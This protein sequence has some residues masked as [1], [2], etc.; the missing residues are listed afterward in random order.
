MIDILAKHDIYLENYSKI[1][2][3]RKLEL[4]K[5][6]VIALVL[7]IFLCIFI[8]VIGKEIGELY[9]ISDDKMYESLAK[10]Y[11]ITSNSIFD[12]EALKQIG[13]TQ[14]LQ[15]FWPYVVCVFAYLFRS[16][17]AARFL[18]VVLSIIAVKLIYDLVLNISENH[19]TAMRAAKLY[20][21]LPYPLL[22]CCFPI[23]DIYL[24]VAVLYT[25]ILFVKFQNRKTI[26]LKNYF[27]CILL[28]IGVYFTRGAVVEIMALF[29]IAFVIMRFYK[30][31][32][33][34]AIFVCILFAII[35][36]YFFG[37]KILDSF[38][39]K[40]DDYGGKGQSGTMI[41]LIQ[42]GNIT[43][44]YKLPFAY[45]FA[46]LQPFT[47]PLSSASILNIWGQIIYYGNLTIV[48]IACGN[49]L[50]IFIKKKN[51]L[52]WICSAVVYCAVISLSLGVFRHYLFLLPIELINY[53]LYCEH[54]S[55]IKRDILLFF[56]CGV[57]LLFLLYSLVV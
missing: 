43:E 24:T 11:L 53:S 56:T 49:F 36:L 5:L 46:S 42:M 10:S 45:F 51:F 15:V 27:I 54:S 22:V 52:F 4:K 40:I 9:F 34:G 7:R 38:K 29:L 17:Y 37:G 30:S 55:T 47:L 26:S 20:A 44:I 31:K 13:A 25:F 2:I 12:V 41:S 35:L 39:T 48:P 6:L 23:K 14:Y 33:I 21:F 3:S 8:L 50:Y 16:I 32:K 19:K 28:L 18:N 57:F 1:N